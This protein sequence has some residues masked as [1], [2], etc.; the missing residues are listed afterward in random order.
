MLLDMAKTWSSSEFV[1]LDLVPIQQPI[2]SKESALRHRVSWVVANVLQGLPF[3]DASF[4]FV[5]IRFLNAGIPEKKWPLLLAEVSRVLTPNG[6]LEIIETDMKIFGSQY[7]MPT[8]ELL[9][10]V[11][12]AGMMHGKLSIDPVYAAQNKSSAQRNAAGCTCRRL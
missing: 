1:G 6:R 12:N 5:H 4:D 8:K 10:E 9:E 7:L 2:S 3:P 11:L